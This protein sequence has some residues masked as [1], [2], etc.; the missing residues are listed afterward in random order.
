L[1]ASSL[2]SSPEHGIYSG[3]RRKMN[4]KDIVETRPA[5]TGGLA[6]GIAVLICYFAGIDDPAVLAA[7]AVVVG[8]LPGAITAWV[9]K[10]RDSKQ[11]G[12]KA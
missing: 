10:I 9:V 8:A 2:V 4:P 11:S 7:L 6:A 3:R 5:E 1:L 12:V